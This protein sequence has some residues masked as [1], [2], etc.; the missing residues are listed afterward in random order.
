MKQPDLDREYPERTNP[1]KVAKSDSG[2][3]RING[4]P[5]SDIRI[6]AG[7][8]NYTRYCGCGKCDSCLIGRVALQTAWKE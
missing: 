4:E 2:T 6:G 7:V 8:M 5:V 3:L 1:P